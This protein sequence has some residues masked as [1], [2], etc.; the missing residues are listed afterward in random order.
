MY[1]YAAITVE[2][3]GVLAVPA[4]AAV[5]QGE[6]TYCYRV[7]GD[8]AVRT[9][10]QAGLRDGQLIEVV[11]GQRPGKDGGWMAFT[12]EEKVIVAPPASLTDGQAVAASRNP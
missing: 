1:A 3:A 5:T 11:K 9:P 8:K 4:A 2:H 7:D 6:Q 10:V 12:G